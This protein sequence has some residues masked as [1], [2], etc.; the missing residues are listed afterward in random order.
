M[1]PHALA[2]TLLETH[3]RH[4][5][6]HGARVWR[7]ARSGDACPW[8]HSGEER[9][10]VLH[11]LSCVYRLLL[12]SV[13]RRLVQLFTSLAPLL[14]ER[15]RCKQLWR[16]RRAALQCV[17]FGVHSRPAPPS[18]ALS[19]RVSSAPLPSPVGGSTAAPSLPG[20]TA[21]FRPLCAAVPLFVVFVMRQPSGLL[22]FL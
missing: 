17:G 6:R 14:T 20:G 18:L 8:V 5:F 1:S 7:A 22:S 3:E 9:I 12:L 4:I 16:S 21:R 15:S 19:T 11:A 2:R 10:R 13:W